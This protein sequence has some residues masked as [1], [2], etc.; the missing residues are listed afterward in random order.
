MKRAPYKSMA[1]M[2][3]PMLVV[4]VGI[5][6]VVAPSTYA[7]PVTKCTIDGKIVYSDTLCTG[8]MTGQT[9]QSPAPPWT[10]T[11]GGYAAD[12]ARRQQYLTKNPNIKPVYKSAIEAGVVIPGMS[13]EQALAA[14]GEPTDR[15]LS[16]GKNYSRWQWVY[17]KY[18][19]RSQYVYIEDGIV[20]GAN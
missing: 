6:L 1:P 18:G 19:G 15:N 3:K 4:A 11:G 7:A 12:K 17:R 2:H 20:T 13:E 8:Q 10:A 16:Q 9:I 5:M 14:L